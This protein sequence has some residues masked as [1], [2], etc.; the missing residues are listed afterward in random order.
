MFASTYVYPRA[1]DTTATPPNSFKTSN[2]GTDSNISELVLASCFEYTLQ[3]LQRFLQLFLSNSLLCSALA[4]PEQAASN[5]AAACPLSAA[6]WGD[7]Q[8]LVPGT[9][10]LDQ[11]EGLDVPFQFPYRQPSQPCCQFRSRLPGKYLFCMPLQFTKSSTFLLDGLEM[12]T[13]SRQKTKT[14]FS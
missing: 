12:I 6:S 8:C 1:K 2:L 10:A 3:T 14:F 5:P 7:A 4:V 11:G 13:K 9:L